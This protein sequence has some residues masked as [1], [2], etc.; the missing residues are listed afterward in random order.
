M[1]QKKEENYKTVIQELSSHGMSDVAKNIF[2]NIHLLI[3]FYKILAQ[4]VMNKERDY[5][6]TLRP[7][8]P[9][10]KALRLSNNG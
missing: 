3:S 8:R 9:D 1:Q 10:I 6:R 5:T 2:P 7:W 4:L